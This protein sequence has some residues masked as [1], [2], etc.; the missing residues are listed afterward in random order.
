MPERIFNFS[1]GPGTLPYSVLQEAATDIVNFKNKGIGLI[2]IPTK[3]TGL[4]LV[5]FVVL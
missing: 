4:L 2:I 5:A 3:A 1:P